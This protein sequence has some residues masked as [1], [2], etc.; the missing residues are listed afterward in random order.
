MAD[1]DELNRRL[2]QLRGKQEPKLGL[3]ELQERIGKLKGLEPGK[4]TAPPIT[5][6]T[7]P[8]RRSDQQK[9]EDLLSQLMHESNIDQQFSSSGR[10][11][12]DAEMEQRLR[13]LQQTE[14]SDHGSDCRGQESDHS[15]GSEVANIVRKAIAESQLPQVTSEGQESDEEME[16]PWCV[17]CNEDA[18][19][20]CLDCDSDLY[21]SDCFSEFHSDPD[22]RKHRTKV[23]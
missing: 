9:T 20:C 2:M 12:S 14:T 13:R 17:I 18:K 16:Y 3:D 22:S 23:L 4:Y 7:S 5:V 11:I 1:M 15:P 21:C 8:D 10:R 6:Y 19:V